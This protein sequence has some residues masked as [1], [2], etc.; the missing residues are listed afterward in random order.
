V[1]LVEAA[2]ID[3]EPIW[4]TLL[5]KALEGRNVKEL[6][7]NVG[8]GGGAPAAVAASGGAG[9]AAATEAPK[10][11]EKEEKKEEESDDDMVSPLNCRMSRD[12][13][14]VTGL[15]LVR[16]SELLSSFC[17]C[18]FIS[19]RPRSSIQTSCNTSTLYYLP[20][21]STAAK[22]Y[23]KS[24]F[25]WS[26]AVCTLVRKRVLQRVQKNKKRSYTFD[27]FLCPCIKSLGL[28]RTFDEF[29]CSCHNYKELGP[30]ALP[31]VLS[32]E[33]V[34]RCPCNAPNLAV[35]VDCVIGERVTCRFAKGTV[36]RPGDYTYRLVC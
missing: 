15:W 3:L 17:I 14:L 26:D 6:L 29:L 1:T 21:T 4:A 7:S 25:W 18:I 35:N 36:L 24:P 20:S 13:C 28:S 9:A 31:I 2:G 5:A 11:E 32:I 19:A 34:D 8:S 30:F 16:L 23:R 27:E 12:S 22:R 10:E 33:I